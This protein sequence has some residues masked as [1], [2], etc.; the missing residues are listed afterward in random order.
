MANARAPARAG[1]AGL[2]GVEVS[3]FSAR[4][5]RLG[6]TLFE[7]RGNILKA[8]RSIQANTSTAHQFVHQNVSARRSAH[9]GFLSI[10]WKG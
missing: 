8:T 1:L 9:L 5:K 10:L 6:V 2:V 3:D 7:F 4:V